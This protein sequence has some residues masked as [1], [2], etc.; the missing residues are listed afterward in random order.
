MTKLFKA[1]WGIYMLLNRLGP[2]F[3]EKVNYF[4]SLQWEMTIRAG[5]AGD[6]HTG[7]AFIER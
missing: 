3:V 7:I 6:D 1:N 5:G 2:A 4:W